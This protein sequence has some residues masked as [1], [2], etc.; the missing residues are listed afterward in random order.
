MKPLIRIAILLLLTVFSLKAGALAPPATV[1]P[2]VI[3]NIISQSLP[4]PSTPNLKPAMEAPPEAK[5][6]Y[7]A[8]AA[9]IRFTLKK[10]I[11]E[12]NTVYTTKEL[13][14]L[15]K[16]KL[17]KEMSVLDFQKIVQSITN[18]YRN[19]GYILSRAIIP[20]QH[21]KNG[22]V[23]IRVIEGFVD[24]VKIEGNAR[25]ANT[26]LQKY[27]KNI[28]DSRP[29]QLSVLDRY[30][31]LSNE[32]PGIQVKGVLQPSKKET[33]AA[34]LVLVVDERRFNGYFAYDNYGTRYLGPH[35]DT[36]NITMNSGF[37]GGDALGVTYLI[38]TRPKELRFFDAYYQV[39][40]GN[41]GMQFIFDTN[42][43]LTEAG[44]V[45]EEFDVIGSAVTYYGMLQYPLIR[46][47]DQ[48]LTLDGS[49][50]YYNG[51]VTSLGALLYDDNVRSVKFGGSYLFADRF[52]GS[53][54]AT[55]HLEQGLPIFGA[56]SSPDS[57]FT[58]RYGATGTFTKVSLQYS[59]DQALFDRFSAF[60]QLNGQYAFNPLLSYEQF[61][62]GGSLLGR[63]YDPAEII[64]D[65]GLAGSAELRMN[66]YPGLKF[67]Q[68]GQLYGYYDIGKV[69]NLRNLEDLFNSYTQISAA[70]AGGGIRF[71]FNK[72]IN[73]NLMITQPLTKQVAA[74]ELIGRGKWPRLFFG[75]SAS[76]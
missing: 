29:L 59:R 33:A 19:N 47:L 64:G 18:Y 56:T 46:T 71:N 65:Q 68:S 5:V 73:G 15:Y 75:V 14:Q 25:N 40:V 22:V 48:N 44:F 66:F 35:E 13:E 60:F 26:I 9:K 31:R 30:L 34:T 52:K 36:F 74:E 58:S 16:D 17:N 38:T 53:N 43:S 39:P 7:N 11:L 63:G 57:F 45:L 23:R 49:L 8:Q 62:F 42:K 50:V 28:T 10:I 55:L 76:V 24:K 12:G 2:G 51:V 70:S 20:P 67:F 54:S 21:A 6:P 69:W 37:I 1:Q 72:Y 32:L 41:R 3:G 27:G 4:A 61:T